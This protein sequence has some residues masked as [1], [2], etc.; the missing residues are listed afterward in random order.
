[1]QLP[2]RQ[3]HDDF[4]EPLMYRAGYLIIHFDLD[5]TFCLPNCELTCELQ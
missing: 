4:S 2:L 5:L 3:Q 1:M